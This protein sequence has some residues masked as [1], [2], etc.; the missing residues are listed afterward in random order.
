MTFLNS[1]NAWVYIS[2]NAKYNSYT[3][4]DNLGRYI[5]TGTLSYVK[6]A[7]DVK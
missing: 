4:N 1:S 2:F 7:A 5:A 3:A 6:K